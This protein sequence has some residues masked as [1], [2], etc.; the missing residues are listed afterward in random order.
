MDKGLLSAAFLTFGTIITGTV[1][2]VDVIEQ[3]KKCAID[4]TETRCADLMASQSPQV[5]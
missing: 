4:P 3:L 1:Y 2:A 5:K